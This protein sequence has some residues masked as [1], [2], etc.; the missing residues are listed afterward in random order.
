MGWFR[1]RWSEDSTK[2][3]L[4]QLL[5]LIGSLAF[6]VPMDIMAGAVGAIAMIGAAAPDKSRE[7]DPYSLKSP[8][9]VSAI[10]LF[11]LLSADPASAQ[12]SQ[13]C[14]SWSG[15]TTREDGSALTPEELSHY[16]LQTCA[17][18]VIADQVTD[19]SFCEPLPPDRTRCVQA[20]ATDSLGLTSDLS[21]PVSINANPPGKVINVTV[22]VQV[23][24]P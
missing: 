20:T 17:G 16:T 1:K 14:Y 18:D 21:D 8:L 22:T 4:T 15:P 6:Q 24:T 13:L 23:S 11:I 7:K 19:T 3:Q 9:L 5:T 10:A 2:I 12:T